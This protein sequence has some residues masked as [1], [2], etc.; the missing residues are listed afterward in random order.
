MIDKIDSRSPNVGRFAARTG[1]MNRRPTQE[2]EEINMKKILG[3]VWAY[4]K[5][6]KNLLT[7]GL[8]GVGILALAVFLP[9]PAIYRVGI[10]LAVVAFNIGRM[11]LTRHLK[12]VAETK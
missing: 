3:A 6:W 1:R 4:L 2:Q 8:I 12:K 9:V 10:L 11:A 7:H 5:D